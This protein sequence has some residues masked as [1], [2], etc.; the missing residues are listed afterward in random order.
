M[1]MNHESI[2]RHGSAVD[3]LSS[4]SFFGGAEGRWWDIACEQ[5]KVRC[6]RGGG[7]GGGGKPPKRKEEDGRTQQKKGSLMPHRL[8]LL[9]PLFYRT[10]NPAEG[11]RQ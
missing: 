2:S 9:L 6:Y 10:R 4:S 3:S 1:L 5:L 11:G 8:L 7:G